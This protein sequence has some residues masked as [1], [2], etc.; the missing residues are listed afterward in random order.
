L[1]DR[2]QEVST[3]TEAQEEETAGKSDAIKLYP[4]ADPFK[5]QKKVLQGQHF[6]L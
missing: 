2:D 4:E 5:F 3:T 6:S 1:S